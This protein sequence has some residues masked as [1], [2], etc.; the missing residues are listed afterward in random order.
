MPVRCYGLLIFFSLHRWSSILIFFTNLFVCMSFFFWRIDNIYF[1]PGMIYKKAN[2]MLNIKLYVILSNLHRI[3]TIIL[4]Q[5]RLNGVSFPLLKWYII[6]I[7]IHIIIIHNILNY[8]KTLY[9]R[10]I[11]WFTIGYVLIKFSCIGAASEHGV[12][13][14]GL[15]SLTMTIQD[16]S[17]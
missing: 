3:I 12:G 1:V 16:V 15:Y 2:H 13:F 9:L 8:T 11:F 4:P 5:N 6:I 17:T 7:N 14:E 10:I